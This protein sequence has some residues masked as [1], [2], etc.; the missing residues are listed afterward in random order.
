[1]SSPI[2]PWI[3]YLPVSPDGAVLFFHLINAQSLA[4]HRDHPKGLGTALRASQF[5]SI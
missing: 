4:P 1:M 5:I 2:E 3:G